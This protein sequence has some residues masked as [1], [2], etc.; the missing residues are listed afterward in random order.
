[1]RQ[2]TDICLSVWHSTFVWYAD[3][4]RQKHIPSVF[5]FH[6]AWLIYTCNCIVQKYTWIYCQNGTFKWH[7]FEKFSTFA[8]EMSNKMK[9]N[10]MK[11]A[12]FELYIFPSVFIECT[13]N[14]FTWK[15]L[16]ILWCCCVREKNCLV[17]S[18]QLDCHNLS[19]HKKN[20][21]QLNEWAEQ[22]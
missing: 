21:S 1:M 18:K 2:R 20:S 6:S 7:I 13:V 11:Q 19:V 14:P 4:N 12:V 3:T 8:H 17:H 15:F 16:C 22:Q 5:S 10:E 9:W